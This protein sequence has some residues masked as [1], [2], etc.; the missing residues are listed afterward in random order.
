MHTIKTDEN[1]GKLNKP[2][3]DSIN[4]TKVC[5]I[6]NDSVLLVLNDFVFYCIH[7]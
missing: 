4:Y 2:L 5:D 7:C 3:G 1:W 6:V